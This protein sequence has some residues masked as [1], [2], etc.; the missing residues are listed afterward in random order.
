LYYPLPHAVKTPVRISQLSERSGV[1]VPTIKYY[2]REGLLPPGERTA[3]NQ[4]VYDE[5]HLRRLALIRSLRE[6]ADL[7]IAAIR[8][9][10]TALDAPDG[11]QRSAH[12]HTALR[13]L[14]AERLDPSRPPAS[15]AAQDAA[16][17]LLERLDWDVEEASAGRAMLVDALDA[18]ERHWPGTY[19]V[20]GLELYARI[21]EELAEL[22][23][24]SDWSPDSAG[25][26]AL[27]YAVLGTILYEPVILALRRLAHVDRHRR[28]TARPPG[29]TGSS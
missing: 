13:A 26:D 10:L 21:A 16:D 14:E 23:I 25:P 5:T 17:R 2:V 15:P 28:L 19:T 8:R 7:S 24:P 3:P 20:D 9:T 11:R 18:I 6:G 12:V 1:S 29:E 4:A 27:V 22:E